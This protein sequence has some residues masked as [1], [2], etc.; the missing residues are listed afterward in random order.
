MKIRTLSR[1]F[2]SP[3]FSE[4]WAVIDDEDF[5]PA[6]LCLAFYRVIFSLDRY[7]EDQNTIKMMDLIEKLRLD[8]SVE[9]SDRAK[10]TE[11][12]K[13]VPLLFFRVGVL[14]YDDVKSF[15]TPY[16]K[17]LARHG[18]EAFSVEGV[19]DRKKFRLA[20]F[21]HIAARTILPLLRHKM[22][23]DIHELNHVWNSFLTEIKNDVNESVDKTVLSFVLGKRQQSVLQEDLDLD[24][25]QKSS[26]D[27]DQAFFFH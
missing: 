25:E 3:I 2:L 16:I 22:G 13:K 18:A 26:K 7:G 12:E 1:E 11:E 14:R 23:H 24:L 10:Y 17:E 6:S 8:M 5:S 9:P 15:R 20:V 21:S 19:F 27:I 4:T